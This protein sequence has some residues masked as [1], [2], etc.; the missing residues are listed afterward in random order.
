MFNKIFILSFFVLSSI[1][2]ASSKNET[3]YI[4]LNNIKLL[5]SK[6][7]AK[8]KTREDYEKKDNLP[9]QA[10]NK[11]DDLNPQNNTIDMDG[12]VNFNKKTKSVDSIKINLGKNF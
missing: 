5:N 6:I 10:M 8:Q 7:N 12:T 2:F 9:E 3:K 4:D 11:K 1:T